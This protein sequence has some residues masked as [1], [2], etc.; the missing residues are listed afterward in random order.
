MED[1]SNA[2]ANA[3]VDIKYTVDGKSETVGS[4][5]HTPTMLQA[6]EGLPDGA[7]VEITMRDENGDRTLSS[8]SKKAV[9]ASIA[10]SIVP[11]EMV[12]AELRKF[13]QF[14]IDHSDTKAV[15]IHAVVSSGEGDNGIG[16]A[17]TSDDCTVPQAMEFVNCGEANVDEFVK[18]AKLSIP[19]RGAADTVEGGVV[20]PSKDQIA[21]LS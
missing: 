15:G 18:K 21:S 1:N 3:S 7:D 11:P 12:G 16:F 14:I 10:M 5:F 20:I 19:G 13:A 6:V 9:L 4:R 17:I 8:G 2:P